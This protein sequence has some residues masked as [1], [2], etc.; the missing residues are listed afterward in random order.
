MQRLA[1]VIP[2]LDRSMQICRGDRVRAT[3]YDRC[4]Q[5]SSSP[6]FITNR[7]RGIGSHQLKPPSF[8]GRVWGAR[9]L[10]SEPDSSRSCNGPFRSNHASPL[11]ER[12]NMIMSIGRTVFEFH[13]EFGFASIYACSCPFRED[14]RRQLAFGPGVVGQLPAGGARPRKGL[15]PKL[16]VSHKET[17]DLNHIT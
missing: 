13:P 17:R 11:D 5:L 8:C 4:Q 9:L 7:L 15:T 1:R 14:K 6:G 16:N 12:L 3:I 10:A 2:A